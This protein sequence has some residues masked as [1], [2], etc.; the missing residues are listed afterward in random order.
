MSRFTIAKWTIGVKIRSILA[1]AFLI[2]GILYSAVFLRIIYPSYIQMEHDR[3]VTNMERVIFALERELEDLTMLCTDWADWDATYAFMENN[4]PDY[5][6][7]N[8]AY[9]TFRSN[10]INLVLIAALD[11][12]VKWIKTYDLGTG[13]P[14]SIPEFTMDRLSPAHPLLHD[15]TM[16]ATGSPI[17]WA[18]VY[19]TT[20]GLMLTTTRPIRTTNAEGPSRGFLIM[21]R[22]LTPEL[23]A[24]LNRQTHIDFTIHSEPVRP[25][26]CHYE[27][28]RL[29]TLQ[30][31]AY[32]IETPSDDIIRIFADFPSLSGYRDLVIQAD[33]PRE[34]YGKGKKAMAYT[35]IALLLSL[36]IT[37]ALTSF[38]LRKIINA[39]ISRLKSHMVNIK[40]IGDLESRCPLERD[41]GRD[42][43]LVLAR[44]FNDMLNRVEEMSR[45]L[46]DANT[47]L[48]A[49]TRTDPLTRIANRREFDTHLHKQWCLMNRL[50]K[51]I[52]LIMC[53]VDFFKTYNDFY[54][55]PAGDQCLT[56][57][58]DVLQ[59]SVNR[60][61][62]LAA[63]YG[64]EEFALILPATDL[65]RACALAE[66]IRHEIKALHIPH[67]TSKVRPWVTLS[68][69]VACLVPGEEAAETTLVEMADQALYRAKES[70]K[71]GWQAFREDIPHRD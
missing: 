43:I 27:G 3:A 52:S 53:D 64:G 10:R 46:E 35:S 38:L 21:G 31:G 1:L 20:Q 16:K 32:C 13:A 71:D 69:G 17:K 59:Q 49:L 45:S 23:V 9:E 62:D 18:G 11:G 47:Q 66:K 33:L 29:S 51:P 19:P 40:R 25:E 24:K 8:Y 15:D 22:M 42:E 34:I 54:G 55:H 39:P 67:D 36:V 57:V 60:A 7:K 4:E 63:R 12:T 61:Y 30:S 37:L 14:L 70:G 26:I 48:E 56:A 58:A 65:E 28:P 2:G 44:E 50:G 5:I 41:P 6:E 68:M